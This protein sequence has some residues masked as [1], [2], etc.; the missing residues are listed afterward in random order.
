MSKETSILE[1]ARKFAATCES[2]A[3]FSNFLF[4]PVDG[5]VAT[6]YL[7]KEDRAS[8]LRTPEY[9]MVRQLMADSMERT[10][11]VDGAAPKKSGRFVVRLPPSLHLALEHE[12]ASEGVSL[13]QLVVVKLA[14]RL[15]DLAVENDVLVVRSYLEIRE[16]YS[17][18]KVVADPVADRAFLDR[19]RELGATGTDFELNWT[20]MNARKSG[21]LPSQR[22]IGLKTKP[23]YA[24]DS[25][26]YEYACE[27]AARHVQRQAMKDPR[28][29]SLR[30]VSLDRIIC[31]PSLV[32]MFDD[33]AT[34]LAPGFAALDYRWTALGLRKANRLEKDPS[35][36]KQVQPPEVDIIGPTTRVKA[37][38]LPAS[39]GLYLLRSDD[40]SIFVGETDN[41]RHRIERHIEYCGSSCFPNWLYRPKSGPVRLGIVSLP[42]KEEP[43]RRPLELALIKELKPIFNLQ[44]PGRRGA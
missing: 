44:V 9:A 37:S 10:G 8:F 36:A 3:D 32:A 27:I 24:A 41:L 28:Y 29:S 6:A 38:Q 2:W 34:K 35:A 31:D 43:A 11:L 17:A 21:L 18:D 14:A 22:S 1:K 23:F 26:P 13:N 19:C 40:A 30:D 25:D 33:V 16:S 15:S 12:A 5:L 4:N 20:L 39:Q 42:G 7:N